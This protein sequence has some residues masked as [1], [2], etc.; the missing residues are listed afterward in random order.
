MHK[1]MFPSESYNFVS[2]GSFR[3]PLPRKII[4]PM[5]AGT[6]SDEGPIFW[7]CSWLV[8]V[9][10][11]TALLSSCTSMA[12]CSSEGSG[13]STAGSRRYISDTHTHTHTHTHIYIMQF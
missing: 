2:K 4:G 9:M 6:H 5:C 7:S 13:L 11:P 12:F 10:A 1:M 3:F 8:E